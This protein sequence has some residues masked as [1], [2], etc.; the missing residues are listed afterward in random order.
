MTIKEM[1]NIITATIVAIMSLTA[2]VLQAQTST[3][4]TVYKGLFGDYTYAQFKTW[5]DSTNCKESEQIRNVRSMQNSRKP[6]DGEVIFTKKMQIFPILIHCISPHGVITD[7]N[8][9]LK[10]MEGGAHIYLIV[11]GQ[12]LAKVKQMAPAT[13][14]ICAS[15]KGSIKGN[16]TQARF[17]AEMAEA[18]LD[19]EV[20]Q[21]LKKNSLVLLKAFGKDI[22]MCGEPVI[23]KVKP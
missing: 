16:A 4:E 23:V 5:R 20:V 10:I 9:F 14:I 22:E 13:D 11:N 2:S 21:Y 15:P 12:E 1:R 6:G 17:L 18:E 8:G 7:Y 3:T 19:N